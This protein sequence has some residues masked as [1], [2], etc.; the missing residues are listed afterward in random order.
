MQRGLH[1]CI[2]GGRRRNT[3]R[4]GKRSLPAENLV[5]R[6]FAAAAPD[7]LWTADITYL[8]TDEGFLYLAFVL[9]ASFRRLVNWAL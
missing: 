9:G 4:R 6:D 1:G 3:T 7:K 2:R 8:N 5:R